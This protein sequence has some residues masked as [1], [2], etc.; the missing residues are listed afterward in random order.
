[1]TRL[2]A[3]AVAMAVTLG[4]CEPAEATLHW[5][6]NASVKVIEPYQGASFV[7]SFSVS[8]ASCTNTT[9]PDK[10]FYVTVGVDGVDT[11]QAK[12]LLAIALYAKVQ[13]VTVSYLYDD[14]TSNCNV[15]AILIN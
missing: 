14:S 10:Y 9:T 6:N 1:M 2:A 15:S 8:D 7:I 3:L 5:V 12:S 4:L 11:D 13:A